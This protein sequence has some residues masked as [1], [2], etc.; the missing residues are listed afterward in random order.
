MSELYHLIYTSKVVSE[1]RTEELEALVKQAR[2]NNF[3]YQVT[4]LL[5]YGEQQ[6]IQVLEGTK[7]HVEQI[8]EKI[9]ADKRHSSIHVVEQKNI[10]K[11]AFLNWNMGL[12]VFSQ[13]PELAD[14]LIEQKLIEN[15]FTP[16]SQY[17]AANLVDVFSYEEFKKFIA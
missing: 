17:N 9:L 3:I 13:H 10:A 12:T 7:E 8:F 6:F 15:K 4:G 14:K 5:V 16:V 2:F 1:F 11:R